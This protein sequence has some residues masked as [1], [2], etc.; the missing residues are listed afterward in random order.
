V[1]VGVKLLQRQG[2][3]A[4]VVAAPAQILRVA[5]VRQALLIQEAAAVVAKALFLEQPLA[6]AVQAS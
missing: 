2:R 5:Q 4:L 6:W 3:A 1:A